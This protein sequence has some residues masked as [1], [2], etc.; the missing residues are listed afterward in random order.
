VATRESDL[1]SLQAKKRRLADLTALSTITVVLLDPGAAVKPA[2][3]G[4]PGFL[5][6]LSRGWHALLASLGVVLTVLGALL[7]WLIVIGV[8][9]WALIW[10]FRRWMRRRTPGRLPSPAG[11]EK[12]G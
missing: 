7:P 5:G 1:A 8:P 9:L 12:T 2:G 6:G 4:P 3:T 11:P 10:A